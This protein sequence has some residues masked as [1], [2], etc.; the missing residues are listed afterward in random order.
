MSDYSTLYD[1]SFDVS[2]LLDLTSLVRK[3]L[4]ATTPKTII[5]S[6]KNTKKTSDMITIRA[7]PDN[8]E[9]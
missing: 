1:S 2:G 7:V 8:L 9:S 3:N 6:T 5:I 4:F